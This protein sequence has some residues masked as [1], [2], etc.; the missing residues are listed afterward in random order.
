[1]SCSTVTLDAQKWIVLEIA[2]HRF[3]QL[4]MV[5]AI[6]R[7]KVVIYDLLVTQDSTVIDKRSSTGQRLLRL[8]DFDGMKGDLL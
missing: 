6:G 3:M 8:G 2:D 7:Y 4:V 5:I 1:M